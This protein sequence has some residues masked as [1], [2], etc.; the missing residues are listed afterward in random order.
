MCSCYSKFIVY[1]VGCELAAALQSGGLDQVIGRL[2]HGRG[3]R[4]KNRARLQTLRFM[5]PA[6]LVACRFN[7]CTRSV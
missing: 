1:N 5:V 4:A 7:Y 2:R 3:D 6:L